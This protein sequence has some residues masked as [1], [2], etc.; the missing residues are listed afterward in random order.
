[1]ARIEESIKIMRP[2]EKVFAITT[3]AKSWPKY[4]TII[5]SSEQTSPGPVGVHA[6]FKGKSHLMGLTMNWTATA[7]EYEPY[8]H[9]G[10]NITSAGMFIEQHNTYKPVE[11]GTE[12]TLLY[13]IKVRGIFKLFSSMMISTMRKELKK[14]LGNLK[15]VLEAQ[16]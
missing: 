11:G 4:Q 12:F 3:D 16:P 5:P 9:F 10:K 1:M 7:T 8:K 6:T 13:V 2:P 15:N 14:S